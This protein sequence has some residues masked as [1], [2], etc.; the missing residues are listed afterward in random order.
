MLVLPTKDKNKI[1]QERIGKVQR[2][3][4]DATIRVN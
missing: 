2:I 3:K 4:N 1:V